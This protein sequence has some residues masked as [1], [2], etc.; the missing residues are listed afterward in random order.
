MSEQIDGPVDGR[1]ARGD[2]TR[3]RILRSSIALASVEGLDGLTIGRVAESAGLKKANIQVLFGDKETLQIATL[4]RAV[5]EYR[6]DVVAPALRKATAAAQLHALVNGWFNFVRKR[7]LPGG[8]LINA[9]S[10]EFRAKPGR[11]RDR[12]NEYRA[13]TRDRFRSL[14]VAGRDA[15]EFR[16]DVDVEEIVFHLTAYQAT[17]NIAALMG[18]TTQFR[19]AHRA[20]LRCIDAGLTGKRKARSR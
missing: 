10:S 7:K 17:A 19:R 20:S 14:I 2:V 4:D 12:I 5:E 11:V 13:G 18:D 3:S 6:A 8:C 9:V 15:G 16:P 1:R